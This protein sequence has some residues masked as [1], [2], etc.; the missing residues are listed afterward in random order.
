MDRNEAR[1]V[2]NIFEMVS[3]FTDRQPSKL[4][5]LAT[6][7]QPSGNNKAILTSAA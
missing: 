1:R 4:K 3:G 5:D 6:A 7:K 2:C